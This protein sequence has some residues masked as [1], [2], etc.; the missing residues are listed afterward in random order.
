MARWV[1]TKLQLGDTLANLAADRKVSPQEIVKQNGV[2]WST[3]AI[4]AWVLKTGG[5]LLKSGAAVF[6]NNSTILLPEEE[7]AVI[8][9]Y[10]SPY[11]WGS[12]GLLA[13]ALFLKYRK[14]GR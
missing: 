12:V 2:A 7:F 13:V 1:P 11:L 3:A 9:P 10:K 4:N 6:T 8:V 14:K 5:T